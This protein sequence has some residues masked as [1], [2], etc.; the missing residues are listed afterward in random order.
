MTPSMPKNTAVPMAW[1]SWQAQHLSLGAID[2]DKHLRRIR[3]ERR[4]RVHDARIG[5]QRLD[6]VLGRSLQR[7]GTAIVHILH[8][9]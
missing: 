9:Q 2:V 6:E 4:E 5:H 8:A 3:V 7:D 1:R